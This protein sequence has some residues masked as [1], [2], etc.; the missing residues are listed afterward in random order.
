MEYGNQLII[1][2]AHKD[3]LFLIYGVIAGDH[4]PE[5]IGDA[6]RFDKFPWHRFPGKQVP[7]VALANEMREN[8]I[9]EYPRL[10]IDPTVLAQIETA[11]L[12]PGNMWWINVEPAK[13]KHNIKKIDWDSGYQPY[14]EKEEQQ[15]EENR[16][17]FT[18]VRLAAH[19]PLG[20]PPPAPES[21][22]PVLLELE[23]DNG[24][25]EP[26]INT[27]YVE[28]SELPHSVSAESIDAMAGY[29]SI[30]DREGGY[31]AFQYDGDYDSVEWSLE[32][33][34]YESETH[35]KL[36]NFKQW[37]QTRQLQRIDAAAD[38]T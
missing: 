19:E 37:R 34:L 26:K 27:Q 3:V 36:P 8:L 31:P 13:R 30:G 10:T 11:L 16:R 9:A 5:I 15:A 22:E 7:S 12:K 38:F 6:Y 33:S 32:S 23:A 4:N 17:R 2:W 29:P 28:L 18:M 20:P 24:T 21:R 25:P 35:V 1:P 14:T